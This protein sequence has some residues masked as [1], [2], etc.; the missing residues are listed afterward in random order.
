MVEYSD[1]HHVLRHKFVV[2]KRYE[3]LEYV[4]G[5]AYGIVCKAHDRVKVCCVPWIGI[6]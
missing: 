6:Y 5:G 2:D 4:G 1:G 3:N